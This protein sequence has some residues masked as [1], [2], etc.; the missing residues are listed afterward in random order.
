MKGPENIIEG[1]MEINSKELTQT[2][3]VIFGISKEQE[4]PT[5][6]IGDVQLDFSQLPQDIEPTQKLTRQDLKL[7][8]NALYHLGEPSYPPFPL[9]STTSKTGIF[10]YDN[11]SLAR[12]RKLYEF[13]QAIK[14]GSTSEMR[15]LMRNHRIDRENLPNPINAIELFRALETPLKT[16]SPFPDRLRMAC[17]PD[18]LNR[19]QF[20]IILALLY[21]LYAQV[22]NEIQDTSKT[23]QYTESL[24]RIIKENL[25]KLRKGEQEEVPLVE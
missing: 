10:K 8:Q 5:L 19:Q 3:P 11:A 23:K 1:R 15:D 9:N 25:E 12:A 6:T 21:S 17:V 24:E 7:L 16:D 14:K 22:E 2:L 18:I 20:L 4:P 13:I